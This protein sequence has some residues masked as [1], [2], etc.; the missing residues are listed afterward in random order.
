MPQQRRE[1]VF[2]PKPAYLGDCLI[3]AQPVEARAEAGRGGLCIALYRHKHR[4]CVCLRSC[5]RVST[6]QRAG[7]I[8]PGPGLRPLGV[9][10][11][12]SG[13]RLRYAALSKPAFRRLERGLLLILRAST[14]PSRALPQPEPPP[15]PWPPSGD[16][17]H[18]SDPP[19]GRS[20]ASLL[21]LPW[22][23]CAGL[24]REAAPAAAAAARAAGRGGKSRLNGRIVGGGGGGGFAARV[25]GGGRT[26]ASSGLSDGC[27]KQAA[28]Q[29]QKQEENRSTVWTITVHWRLAG[30]GGRRGRAPG[31]VSHEA[32]RHRR[33]AAQSASGVGI[34]RGCAPKCKNKSQMIKFRK[35]QTSRRVTPVAPIGSVLSLPAGS[36]TPSRRPPASSCSSTH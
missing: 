7:I 12:T 17:F 6:A 27:R 13:P 21:P 33:R 15:Q 22:A 29:Q 36:P 9:L 32:R 20:C 8:N 14:L 23:L 26:R 3:A 1:P 4:P 34:R 30:G 35:L 11:R 19:F 10:H 24:V 28:E 31:T 5:Q 16:H 18:R 2:R 25:A